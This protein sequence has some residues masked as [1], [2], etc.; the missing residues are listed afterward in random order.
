MTLVTAVALGALIGLFLGALGAGG[1]ILAVPA[2]VYLLGEPARVATSASLVIVG[3]TA[4]T[5]AVVHA[6][7][8]RVRWA[9]GLM[10]GAVGVVASYAGAAANRAADPDVLL[11]AFAGLMV[12]AAVSMLTVRRRPAGTTSSGPMLVVAPLSGGGPACGAPTVVRAAPRARVA[13]L[14]AAGL[15]VGF[16]TG[17]L[18]VGGGFVIVPA[19]IMIL[20]YEMPV[21]V[22]TSLLVIALNSAVATAA[23]VGGATFHWSVIIPFA[24]AAAGSSVAGKHLADRIRPVRLTRAF[25]VLLLAVAAY[26]ATT[27]VHALI[28]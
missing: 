4:L 27:S 8:G 3:V 19:L 1:S 26:T 17:F 5:A 20:G 14:A 25:A 21:A 23:R 15:V 10:F 7:A 24:L 18:G 16:L 9:A 6:R 12:A 11:L 2:L 28:G 22:G 13:R